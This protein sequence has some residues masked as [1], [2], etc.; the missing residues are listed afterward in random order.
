MGRPLE[1]DQE[2]GE[3][4]LDAA[5]ALLLEGGPEAVSVRAVA[6]AVGTTTRAVYSVF[7]SK[8]ALLAA[9]AARGYDLLTGS[10]RGRARTDDALADLVAAGLEGFR[11][12]ALGHPHLFRLTFE[13]MPAELLTTPAVARASQASYDA[14]VDAIEAVMDAGSLARRPVNEV[15]LAFH[16]LCAGLAAAELSMQPPPV[17]TGFWRPARGLDLEAVWRTALTALLTGLP[18]EG[19]DGRRP[20]RRRRG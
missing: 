19:A 15:A 6:D 18:G 10:V 17:G 20:R 5:E 3:A 2:T 11:R 1:H 7:G 14:L 8:S 13:R 12:F 9:L 16:S 4:L